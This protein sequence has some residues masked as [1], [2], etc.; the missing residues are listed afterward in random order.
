MF[1]RVCVTAIPDRGYSMAGAS[2]VYANLN[3]MGRMRMEEQVDRT[4]MWRSV[5]INDH[6]L[7][8]R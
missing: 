2:A 6:G 3:T 8:T 5:G 7:M 4:C 1:S